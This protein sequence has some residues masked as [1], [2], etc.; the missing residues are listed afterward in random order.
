M[1]IPRASDKAATKDRETTTVMATDTGIPRAI[2]TVFVVVFV[3]LAGF[4]I[5]L[6][7][8]EWLDFNNAWP[9][10]IA[11]IL[12]VAL[13]IPILFHLITHPTIFFVTFLLG[14]VTAVVEAG[15]FAYWLIAG[16]ACAGRS[17]SWCPANPDFSY[18]SQLLLSGFALVFAIIAGV[19]T[20][21]VT[22]LGKF[23]SDRSARE[24]QDDYVKT[25]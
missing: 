4:E 14:G 7:A 13:W 19:S 24:Q 16:A 8:A 22:D 9:Q 12:L 17:T 18:G 10:W 5:L 25:R 21:L 1:S 2:L 15:L 3:M 20:V 23:W 11:F 6:A